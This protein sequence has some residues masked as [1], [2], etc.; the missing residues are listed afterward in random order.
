MWKI[1]REVERKESSWMS[2][3]NGKKVLRSWKWK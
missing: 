1:I 2:G 3:G